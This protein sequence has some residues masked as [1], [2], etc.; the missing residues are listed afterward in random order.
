MNFCIANFCQILALFC[1]WNLCLS[2]NLL[3]YYYFYY[4][5]IVARWF[6]PTD[7]LYF[8]R[9]GFNKTPHTSTFQRILVV[10]IKTNLCNSVI[11]QFFNLFSRALACVPR[12]PTTNRTTVTFVFHTFFSSLARSKYLSIFSTY[13]S[14]HLCHTV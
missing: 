12:A 6:L 1:M 4:Y 2:E 7:M 10:C 8:L 13:L 3:H 5:W 11:F 9:Y 14:S